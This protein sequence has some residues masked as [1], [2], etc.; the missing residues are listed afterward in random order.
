MGG[1]Y[2]A[3]EKKPCPCKCQRRREDNKKKLAILRGMGQRG[4]SSTN[5]VFSWEAPDSKNLKVQFLLS[6]VFVAL[7]QAPKM[8]MG[9]QG[10]TQLGPIHKRTWGE[11]F[12]SF[13]FLL[14][15]KQLSSRQLSL[16]KTCVSSIRMLG[17]RLRGRTATISDFSGR[18]WRN[19]PPRWVIH[20]A[21]CRPAHNTQIHM[22]LVP[23][24]WKTM[25][26]IH[27][28]WRVVG[29][30][31]GRHVDHPSGGQ[32]SPWPAGKITERRFWEGF[33]EG[34]L[35]RAMG[36]TVKKGSEKGS[37]KGF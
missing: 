16:P 11:F 7:A 33:W 8:S 6:R 27:V 30:S 22:D 12:C 21:T 18:S 35:G 28:D 13:S 3:P 34:G 5:T 25:Q 1:G 32:L 15:M 14:P 2:S 31:A 36:F 4:K 23:F 9:A 20:M 24:L 17:V 26:D 37:Q 10:P 19:L 29:W